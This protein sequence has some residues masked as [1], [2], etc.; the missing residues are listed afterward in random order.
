MFKHFDL[1]VLRRD[2]QIRFYFRY[3]LHHEEFRE[4]R[5]SKRG[6][7]LGRIASKPLY[8]VLTP[9]GRIDRTKGYSGQIAIIFIPARARSA[10]ASRLLFTRIP[11]EQVTLANGKRNWKAIRAAAEKAVR[12]KLSK[13]QPNNVS[14]DHDT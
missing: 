13:Y 2:P 11:R 4:V 8:G 5:D 10:R 12:T 7:L 3:P 14:R 1:S 9:D 6:R